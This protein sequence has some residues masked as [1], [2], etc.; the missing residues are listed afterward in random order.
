[1][2][3][4]GNF[5]QLILV[6]KRKKN[7]PV[8]GTLASVLTKALTDEE[9]AEFTACIQAQFQEFSSVS[10]L[11]CWR[12]LFHGCHKVLDKNEC[13][14]EDGSKKPECAGQIAFLIVRGSTGNVIL[15]T[16]EAHT[17]LF[18]TFS[19]FCWK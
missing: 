5:V 18:E 6:K 11:N 4:F 17:L 14:D 9:F 7:V 10:L 19:N 12:A 1:M 13:H 15:F 2:Q 3:S 8:P 16:K